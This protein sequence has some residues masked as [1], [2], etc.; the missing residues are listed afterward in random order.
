MM[1]S[2]NARTVF[3]PS[4]AAAAATPGNVMNTTMVLLSSQ[5][6]LQAVAPIT[7]VHQ[8]KLHKKSSRSIETNIIVGREQMLKE[9]GFGS[10]YIN[11]I[12]MKKFHLL[13]SSQKAHG[14]IPGPL[15]QWVNIQK[16]HKNKLNEYQVRMLDEVGVFCDAIYMPAYQLAQIQK[17]TPKN[18]G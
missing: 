4:H 12:W 2:S 6:H 15:K 8:I 11:N 16:Q 10:D 7:V 5:G 14:H 9:L 1:T 17:K 18:K 3:A 13:T